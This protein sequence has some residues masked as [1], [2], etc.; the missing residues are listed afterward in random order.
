MLNAAKITE[1]YKKGLPFPTVTPEADKAPEH[2][3]EDFRAAET[4]ELRS[5]PLFEESK[6]V[7]E[8]Q[9]TLYRCAIVLKHMTQFAASEDPTYPYN[10]ARMNLNICNNTLQR[11]NISNNCP[12]AENLI[13][14]DGLGWYYA[15]VRLAR[16][17]STFKEIQTQLKFFVK[18]RHYPKE[19]S[20]L[21]HH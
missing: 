14:I 7:K 16:Y 8:H 1:G 5:N 17:L 13:D 21:E 3:P 20:K 2:G 6:G 9:R 18:Q 12:A 10:Q 19:W 4:A 15:R 11:I